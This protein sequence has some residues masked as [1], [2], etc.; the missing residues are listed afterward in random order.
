MQINC[1]HCGKEI[2]HTEKDWY[3]GM[4]KKCYDRGKHELYLL[5]LFLPER[6]RV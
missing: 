2:D 4:C 5:R 3:D 6:L 1:C